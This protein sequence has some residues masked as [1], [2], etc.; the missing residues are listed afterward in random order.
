M[1]DNN[2]WQPTCELRVFP[3]GAMYWVKRDTKT[4][5]WKRI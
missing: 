1:F 4:G 5:Q 3:S 2:Q